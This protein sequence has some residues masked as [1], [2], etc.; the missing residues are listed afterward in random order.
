[1]YEKA[2][3]LRM[4]QYCREPCGGPITLHI[5]HSP[6]YRWYLPSWAED[7]VSILPPLGNKCLNTES[8]DTPLEGRPRHADHIWFWK[9]D[10][11]SLS[12]TASDSSITVYTCRVYGK[13]SSLSAIVYRAPHQLDRET[14]IDDCPG[15]DGHLPWTILPWLCGWPLSDADSLNQEYGRCVRMKS[16]WIHFAPSQG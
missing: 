14:P 9:P 15:D 5:I 6:L 7:H 13:L 1:M 10:E 8:P 16:S 4:V 2:T 3:R 12:C 11:F